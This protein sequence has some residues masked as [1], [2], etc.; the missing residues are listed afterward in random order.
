ME[1]GGS[2]PSERAKFSTVIDMFG[3]IPASFLIDYAK[4]IGAYHQP[5][6]EGLET[7]QWFFIDLKYL[8]TEVETLQ[9][10][11]SSGKRGGSTRS[12]DHPSFT[13]LRNHL[14]REGLI[15][16]QR[17]WCNGDRVL[18]AFYLNNYL[19]LPSDKFASASAMLYTLQKY[20]NYN[21]G[22]IDPTVKNYRE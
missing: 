14:E 9:Y 8:K 20:G 19:M 22:E 15:E 1:Y 10:Y 16:T 13:K 17:N 6:L 3:G 18:K 21:N 7:P 12:V 2:S 5:E 11:S 4:S